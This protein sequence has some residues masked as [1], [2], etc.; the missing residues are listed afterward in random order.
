[1]RYV[2]NL[3]EGFKTPQRSA[4]IKI[5]VNFLSLSGIGTGRINILLWSRRTM[6]LRK[7]TAKTALQLFKPLRKALHPHS[8]LVLT[9]CLEFFLKCS[10]HCVKS[11]QIW[12]IFWPVFFLEFGLNTEIYSVN[13]RIRSECGEIRTRKNSVFRHFSRSA[14]IQ[15]TDTK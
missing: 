10:V 2:K 13:L 4:K 3:Y 14:G 8:A 11:V 5:W 1:M 9:A 15:I 6:L 7:E 12:S